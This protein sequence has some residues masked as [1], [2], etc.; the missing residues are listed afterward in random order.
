MAHLIRS[1]FRAVP[2]VF[3]D[4]GLGDEWPDTARVKSQFLKKCPSEVITLRGPSI[5][6]AFRES[7]FFLEEFNDSPEKQRAERRYNE[8]LV[9]TLDAFC[10]QNRYDGSFVGL[11]REE[12]RNRDRL[13]T[14]RSALYFAKTRQLWICCPLEHWT[15]QDIWAYI[16]E[17]DLPYNELYDL[18]MFGRE[19]ARNGAMFGNIGHRYGRLV[20]LKRNF[21]E[22]FNRLARECP[23]IRRYV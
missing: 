10:H 4:C 13:F 6:S 17:Q 22:W 20:A 3:V 15:A 14:M 2:I 23:E 8:S 21:P 5:L 18:S 7:G 12:S 19:R 16:V 9:K 11:R 1:E